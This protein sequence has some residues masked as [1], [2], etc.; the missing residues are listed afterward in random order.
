M[1]NTKKDITYYNLS[2]MTDDEKK[3]LISECGFDV[4]EIPPCPSKEEIL[5]SSNEA[6]VGYLDLYLGASICWRY[7]PELPRKLL[8]SRRGGRD[9]EEYNSL[10]EMLDDYYLLMQNVRYELV[11]REGRIYG[12]I[13]SDRFTALNEIIYRLAVFMDDCGIKFVDSEQE[14]NA[15]IKRFKVTL[16][17]TAYIDAA[18]E[19]A[20]ERIAS[21]ALQPLL[22]KPWNFA[23]TDVQTEEVTD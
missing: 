20:A 23:W 4:V 16:E 6:V 1:Q 9:C 7:E 22:E 19:T 15:K 14:N 17:L 2:K 12:N 8:L 3:E 21:D 11:D 18:S 10:K 13:E 5:S